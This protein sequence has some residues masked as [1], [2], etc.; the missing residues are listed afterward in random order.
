M[1][2]S[3]VADRLQLGDHVCWVFDDDQRCLAEMS[4][5][6]GAGLRQRQRVLYLSASLLPVA[7]LAGLQAGGVATRSAVDSGQLHV[8]RAADVY[9]SG[10]ELEPARAID[11][12]AGEVSRAVTDGYTGLRWVA[13]MAWV[14]RDPPGAQRLHRYET[15]VNRL[16]LDGL[17]VAVCLYDRRLFQPSLLRRA[18]CAHPATTVAGPYPDWQPQ[19]RVHRDPEHGGLR[20]TGCADAANR[21]ALSA[22]L[23]TLT[24]DRHTADTDRAG[25]QARV[26]LRG[27]TFLDA[28]AAGMLARAAAVI[29]AGLSVTGCSRP[30]TRTLT[31]IGAQRTPGLTL[32]PADDAGPHRPEAAA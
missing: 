29:P 18:A 25:T 15:R 19:L 24:D 7:L 12:L 20:L 10:G 4:R 17:A 23:H 16:F 5:F 21:D 3:W 13:D 27:L 31:L 11:V 28:A 22:A 6:V 14:L 2:E 26:D 8:R 9:L 1:P 32:T 30:V